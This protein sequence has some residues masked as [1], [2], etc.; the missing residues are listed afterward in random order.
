MVIAH[1]LST[2]KNADKIIGF[3]DGAVVEEG[4]H[5]SLMQKEGGVYFH[6]R[7]M[8]TFEKVKGLWSKYKLIIFYSDFFRMQLIGHA[9]TCWGGFRK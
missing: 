4:T 9:S 2:V 8:Q 5:E 3:V 7:N 6:L 1:R